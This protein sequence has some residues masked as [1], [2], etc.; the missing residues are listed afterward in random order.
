EAFGQHE[1][2]TSRLRSIL[3]QYADGM[4][5]VHE[6][7]QNADDAG[8]SCV[9]LLLDEREHGGCSLL[10]PALST[11]QGPALLCYNDALFSPADFA[12]LCALGSDHKLGAANATGRFGLGFNSVYNLTDL[13]SFVTGEHLVFL[14][15]HATHLPGAT[16]AQPGLRVRF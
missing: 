14:D 6:L 16:V 7:I 12:S 9:S 10:K 3:Q 4:G 13:P 15:P 2:L 11:W 1:S 8:A 5:V